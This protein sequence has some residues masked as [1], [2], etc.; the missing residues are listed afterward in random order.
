MPDDGRSLRWRV[1][2]S[3]F[4]GTVYE[5]LATAEGRRRFWADAAP[6]VDDSIHFRFPD[7]TRLVA[8]IVERVPEEV[9][10][11]RYFGGR[12][13]RFELERHERSGTDLTLIEEGIPAEEWDLQLPGWVA[14]LLAL[15]A[16]SDFRVDLRNHDPTRMWEDGWVDG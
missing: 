13:V 9:F 7:G 10:E 8:P 14:V 5:L 15:K 3:A 6:E 16:V 4:P 1:H 12:R 2:L 11:I